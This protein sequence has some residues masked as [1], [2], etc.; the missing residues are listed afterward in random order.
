MTWHEIANNTS[1]L[2][3][4]AFEPDTRIVN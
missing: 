3:I 1:W 4:A 2:A